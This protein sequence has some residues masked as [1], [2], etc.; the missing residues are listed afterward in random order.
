MVRIEPGRFLQCVRYRCQCSESQS[1]PSG[2]GNGGDTILDPAVLRIALRS[3]LSRQSALPYTCIYDVI[4]PARTAPQPR[5]LQQCEVSAGLRA[6]LRVFSAGLR[7][8]GTGLN[9]WRLCRYGAWV[10]ASD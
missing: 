10:R 6:L 2:A 3:A 1:S 4:S 5:N 7:N 9:S 8:Q